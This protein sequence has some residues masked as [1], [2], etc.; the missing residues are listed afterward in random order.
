MFVLSEA[1]AAFVSRLGHGVH[2]A[3]R[4]VAGLGVGPVGVVHRPSASAA[5]QAAA[6]RRPQ[7]LGWTA[8]QRTRGH[9]QARPLCATSLCPGDGA[10][11]VEVTISPQLICMIPAHY[12][13]L[14]SP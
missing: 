11:R 8:V 5:D 1:L 10:S 2:A 4:A 3:A 7:G 9:H 12:V 6:A 14:Y 13:W